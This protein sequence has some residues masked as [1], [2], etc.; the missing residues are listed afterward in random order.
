MAQVDVFGPAVKPR[1][2]GQTMFTSLTS[3][4][5]SEGEKDEL[6][7]WW[8]IPS[9][10][11]L[12]VGEVASHVLPTVALP[13]RE[14]FFTV[15]E[16]VQPGDI[17]DVDGP[18]GPL[19]V[20]VPPEHYPGDECSILLSAP[21]VCVTVPLDAK[22]GDLIRVENRPGA[23]CEVVV[24]PGKR[25]GDTFQTVLPSVIVQVPC[26]AS[27]GDSVSFE[28]DSGSELCAVVPEGSVPGT[29]FA[30]AI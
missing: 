29:F 23:T 20:A 3:L 13:P 12:G 17:I 19:T 10:R 15:P 6:S 26:G 30:V 24:P 22:E 7:K 14:V 8:Y 27:P 18:T 25:E 5:E 2:G 9:A 1:C 28:I 21:S 16:N 4:F 11:L